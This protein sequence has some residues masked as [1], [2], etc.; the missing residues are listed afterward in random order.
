MRRVSL[1]GNTARYVV[2]P[3][4]QL[5]DILGVAYGP[6]SGD[7]IRR[8]H[9]GLERTAACLEAGNP[10]LAALEALMIALP[11][12]SPP[13]LAKLA[14]LEKSGTAWQDQPR[15]PAGQ[16][17]GGQW[18]SGGGGAATDN[19]GYGRSNEQSS[20]LS[21]APRAANTDSGAKR[22]G[23]AAL[24]DDGV[25]RPD[26]DAPSLLLT[27]GPED[28]EEGFRQ[29]I[30]GNEPP[31]D[32][33]S[34]TE[35]FPGLKNEPDLAVPLAPIDGF[36]GIS[37]AANAANLDATMVEYHNLMAQIRAVDP[38]AYDDELLPAGG[39][40][41]LTWQ[42]RNNLI[43]GLRMQRAVAFY[44]LR[45]DIGP[46]QV[47]T[48]KFLQGAVDSAYEQAEK[49]YEARQLP[50][51]LSRAEA[52]GNYVDVQV[53]QDIKE[54]F[55]KWGIRYGQNQN[56]TIN[57]RDSSSFNNRYRIPDARIANVSYD[58]TLA[59]KTISRPQIRGFFAA[60][61]KPD[62]VIIVRPSQQGRNY[63][64]LIQRPANMNKRRRQI[65]PRYR[66]YIPSN[67]DDL[68]DLVGSMMLS[69]PTF[70]DRTGYFP[71]RNIETV[72]GA[73]REGFQI[74]R[75]ELGEECYQKLVELSNRMRAYFEADPEQKTGDTLKGRELI[76]DME[77]LI[78]AK[79]AKR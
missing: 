57:N 33:M 23:P 75:E 25:Y 31:Y 7:A 71:E 67:I 1:A 58:W 30:G 13:A 16:H 36:L 52:I 42:G 11:D 10:A 37:G 12:V 26:R 47:E 43:D 62:A 54:L 45:G 70:V 46:L 77:D 40:A 8:C 27:G 53:R 20:D 17:G 72:F 73:L 32:F 18:T 19:G 63:T 44:K 9:R 3:V 41:G 59:L 38:T 15:L 39:I 69:S 60:D 2:R 48:L 51:R 24:L 49:L 74:A 79:A 35:L 68:L 4:A 64:Y 78:K 21:G 76:L 34:L 50:V 5:G 55:N 65:S 14:M 6:Q 22:E 66:P 61:S 56:I 28:A 29:G